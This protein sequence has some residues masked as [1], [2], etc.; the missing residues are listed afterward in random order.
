MS[1]I[2]EGFE[3]ISV[4]TDGQAVKDGVLVDIASH[5]LNLNARPVNR[6]TGHLYGELMK[7]ADHD[8][9]KL[10]GILKAKLD[11]AAMPKDGPQ[12]GYFY[13]IPPNLWAILNEV[14]GYTLMFPEDY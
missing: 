14:G 1:N 3:I 5:R 13:L 8:G 7:F 10:R 6:I 9:R 11:L 2:F 4:Y 12:D